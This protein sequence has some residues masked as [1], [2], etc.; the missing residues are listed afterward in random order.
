[1]E[2]IVLFL[3]VFSMSVWQW[4]LQSAFQI[5]LS[6][7]GRVYWCLA[8]EWG[9]MG[10]ARVIRM[11][12]QWTRCEWIRVFPKCCNVEMNGSWRTGRG[13]AVSKFAKKERKVIYEVEDPRRHLFLGLFVYGNIGLSQWK[14]VGR[15]RWRWRSETWER[16]GRRMRVWNTELWNLLYQFQH[17]IQ[18]KASLSF[19]ILTSPSSVK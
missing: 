10:T 17:L 2:V 6:T 5:K 19:L 1:M 7:L 16:E 12:L 3:S 11:K 13:R 4:K 9:E 15:W 18:F 14:C 8:I